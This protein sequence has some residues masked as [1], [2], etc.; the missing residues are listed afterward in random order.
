M[1]TGEN[2]FLENATVYIDQ[3][4]TPLVQRGLTWASTYGNH[5]HQFNLSAEA[6]LAR[7]RQ[8]P[9][10]RTNQ[11][12]FDVDA[13][14]SNYYLPVYNDNC[15]DEYA[16]VPELLLW[17]FDSK[18]GFRFQQK[19]ATGSLIG[20]PNWV[21]NTVTKWWQDTNQELVLKYQKIIPSLAFVHIPTYASYAIQAAGVDPYTEPGIND[22]Y[23]L[24]PQ[25]QGWCPDGRDD[26]TW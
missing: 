25:A 3:I 12:V 1:I 24:A 23:P 11:M 15:P 18:G 13:G 20:L 8:W 19:N 16:C 2:G 5:D 26:G 17:F 14:V 6:I 4:V 10:S 9:N 7:E 21:D 22:D